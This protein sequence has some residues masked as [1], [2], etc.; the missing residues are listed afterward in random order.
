M[1][2][3][4]D[5]N[6][7]DLLTRGTSA[8]KV[9]TT[10]WMN[11]PEWLTEKPNWPE[12][13][14]NMES[15]L[16]CIMETEEESEPT[17]SLTTT[18]SDEPGIHQLINLT[19]IS[20]LGKL[21]R[22]TAYMLRFIRNCRVPPDVRTK[23]TLTTDEIHNAMVTWI[24]DTQ[25]QSF[26]DEFTNASKQ[27]S[28]VRQLRLY[29]DRDNTVRCKGRLANA[30]IPDSTKYP[31]LLPTKHRF[32]TLVIQDAHVRQ[33]HAGV[34]GTITYLRETFWIPRIRQ[35]VRSI[36]KKC[37]T[38][39]KVTSKPYQ[40]PDPP[41]LPRDRV[42]EDVPFAVSGVDFAGPLHVKTANATKSKVHICLYTCASTR[43]V[44]LEL[45]PNLSVESFMMG[46]RR[47]TSRHSVPRTLISDNATTFVAASQDIKSLTDSAAIH[48]QLNSTGTSWKF[49]A[50][51]APW[52]GGFYERLIGIT[53]QCL[54]K[55]LGNACV[56]AE[57]LRTILCEVE[58]T[59]ND[60]PLTYT[61]TDAS[62]PNPI[63]PSQLIYG[64]RITTIPYPLDATHDD[65][66]PP[67]AESVNMQLTRRCQ[68]IEHFRTRWK[69]EYLTSLREYHRVTGK[70]SQQVKIGEIVQ[71]HDDTHRNA[72]KLG[73][74]D[75]LLVGED[76]R[77]R[78]VQL[79]TARGYT[80]RP[81]AKLYPLEVNAT[82][83]EEPADRRP[84]ATDEMDQEPST[85]KD[86][87]GSRRPIRAS[88]DAAMTKIHQWTS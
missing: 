23:M 37:V 66:E 60:R 61:S 81:I 3:P 31:Y 83:M 55:V 38:C 88:K 27:S 73:I 9:K 18:T 40:K 57:T 1:Y 21:L 47:F 5:S 53:K 10:L 36:I 77:V 62:D 15:T 2:C 11:G 87:P 72:W 39:R 80:N 75:K 7:A 85:S 68:L 52:F 69:M 12:W 48:E 42:N 78:S 58:A 26:R 17:H 20:S 6:P 34:N 63:S 64:R 49:I 59:V 24:N 32:T 43:A 45:I 44:H 4:T 19:N 29:R 84:N 82:E 16:A 33:L 65:P 50:K 56:D 30:P 67:S 76:N 22:I 41:P 13:N 25:E 71:I 46:F 86:A 70:N 14:G 51:R 8:D 28:I 35:A 74:I 54:R 79:K